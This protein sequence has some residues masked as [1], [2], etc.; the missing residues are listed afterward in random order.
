MVTWVIDAEAPHGRYNPRAARR[1]ANSI[2]IVALE[3]WIAEIERQRR[4]DELVRAAQGDA[5]H[6]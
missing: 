1:V 4:V 5:D 3:S 6:D 2:L